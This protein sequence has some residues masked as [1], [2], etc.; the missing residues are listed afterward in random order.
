MLCTATR[1]RKTFRGFHFFR[2][3]VLAQMRKL[4]NIDKIEQ[5]GDLTRYI[6]GVQVTAMCFTKR[7]KIYFRLVE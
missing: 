5:V 4:N 2:Y 3:I 7:H 6:Q 1:Y